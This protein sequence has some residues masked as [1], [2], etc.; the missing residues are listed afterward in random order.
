VT[1]VGAG[2]PMDLSVVIS[3]YNR[4]A[5]LATCLDALGAQEVPPHVR[6]EVV[7]VDNNCTDD[8]P[9]VVERARSTAPMP[10]RYV[11]EHRQG[12]A[13]G[14]NSGV[15]QTRGR[16]LAFTDDDVQPAADWIA[17][18]LRAFDEHRADA[19]GGRVMPRWTAPV[20]AWIQ[21]WLEERQYRHTHLGILVHPELV[22]ITRETTY[23]PIWGSNAAVTRRGFMDLGG[24]DTRMG[25][26]K[27]KLYG[28]EDTDLIRRAAA[29]DFHIFYDPRLTVWHRIPA[30]RMTRR[31]FRRLRFDDAEGEGLHMG[32]P[33]GRALLGV[34]LYTYRRVAWNLTAWLKAAS[35]RRRDAFARELAL[36]SALGQLWGELKAARRRD[37]PVEDS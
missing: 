10:I 3:T 23:P 24:F 15:A 14:R 27:A 28:G 33:L 19:L 17:T 34:R 30:E 4:S 32:R 35:L 25:R 8:T 2:E 31:H 29:R 20:P 7:V 9:A 22:R 37:R 13:F 11:F 36:H 21:E 16:V 1:V 18:I 26:V 6:W 12:V 5:L